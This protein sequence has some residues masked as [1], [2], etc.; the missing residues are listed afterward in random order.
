MPETLPDL[1]ALLHPMV[2]RALAPP[3]PL[4][5]IH[6]GAR[7]RRNRRRALAGLASAALGAGIMVLLLAAFGNSDGAPPVVVIDQPS[8]TTTTAPEPDPAQAARDAFNTMV[9][10]TA[11]SSSD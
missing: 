5:A 3:Y 11:T 7:R 1:D 9:G 4:G 2:E 10:P 8:T 6:R